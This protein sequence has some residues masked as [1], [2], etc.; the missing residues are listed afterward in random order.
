[1]KEKSISSVNINYISTQPF[2]LFL[3]NK[4]LHSFL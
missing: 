2:D 1:M 3:L 4:D